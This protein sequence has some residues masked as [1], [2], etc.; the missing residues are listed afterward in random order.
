MSS[1]RRRLLIIA[2]NL[3]QSCFGAGFW[4]NTEGWTNDEGWSNG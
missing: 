4:S 3:I 1:F 2:M